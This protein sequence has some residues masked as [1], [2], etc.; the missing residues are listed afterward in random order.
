[1]CI[2]HLEI[3]TEKREIEVDVATGARVA[4]KKNKNASPVSSVPATIGSRGS[5][6]L[7]KFPFVVVGEPVHCSRSSTSS[8]SS[9]D[10]SS[11][12]SSDS[13]SPSSGSSEIL[14]DKK[15]KKENKKDRK[16]RYPSKSSRRPS[17]RLNVGHYR[18]NNNT[19]KLRPM[20]ASDL[21]QVAAGHKTVHKLTPVDGS[22]VPLG[23][24]SDNGTVEGFVGVC[25]CVE[26]HA[27]K[28]SKKNKHE[29][30]GDDKKEKKDKKVKK[31]KRDKKDKKE[32]KND[33]GWGD[34]S[35][36]ETSG[37]WGN[38]D[39]TARWGDDK[40]DSSGGG[41][42]NDSNNGWGDD[43][44]KDSGWGDDDNKKKKKK[45]SDDG[46]GDDKGNK[47]TWDDEKKAVNSD[48]GWGNDNKDDKKG[49]NGK[50]QDENKKGKKGNKTDDETEKSG[51]EKNGKG[52][53]KDQ[54]KK[55]NTSGKHH[56][57][58]KHHHHHHE[59]ERESIRAV[60]VRTDC[61][62]PEVIN[63]EGSE[64]TP[65]DSVH[66]PNS[67]SDKVPHIAIAT[68][69]PGCACSVGGSTT[70]SS[71]SSTTPCPSCYIKQQ[72]PRNYV[73]DLQ[74]HWY[75]YAPGIDL[76]TYEGDDIFRGSDD[77][78]YKR[79]SSKKVPEEE[80]HYSRKSYSE[81]Y[82]H[83]HHNKHHHVPPQV[84]ISNGPN[85]YPSHVPASGF[86]KFKKVFTKP[87]PTAYQTT[88]TV[89]VY[90]I[91]VH[92]TTHNGR[93][94]GWQDMFRIFTGGSTNR[95]AR[96]GNTNHHYKVEPTSSHDSGSRS[97]F[98]GY[99][100]PDGQDGYGRRGD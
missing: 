31:D 19:P 12:S 71:V 33:D 55:D 29:K 89:P 79:I 65:L 36:K 9:S 58:I 80:F 59:D 94:S 41:W 21:W 39:K 44:K 51:N 97:R 50:N 5:K 61:D 43:N 52:G 13:S 4:Q 48:G 7:V 63:E 38:D 16:Y 82:G 15:K 2:P 74:G 100:P 98:N 3:F 14:D 83:R 93:G 73:Q 1:M 96:R 60:T 70:T 64:V 72:T 54:N 35:K 86:M 78:A 49:K 95:S 6:E 90:G 76:D 28:S 87:Q 88:G 77:R 23:C 10:S 47:V 27:K 24:L 18:T 85:C 17:N 25:G 56:V 81:R 8:S 37:G 99:R 40:K 22:G 46:W 57:H 34:D 32:K 66:S 42:S 62:L 67:F 30:S 75:K 53:K 45:K 26:G 20:T 91:P 68:R 11:I 69:S 92:T 84:G